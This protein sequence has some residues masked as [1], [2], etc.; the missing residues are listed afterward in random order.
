[1]RK[2]LTGSIVLS[3]GL[4]LFTG[5][6][7][8]Q[9]EKL[10]EVVLKKIREAAMSGTQLAETAHYL[11]DVSGPRLPGSEGFKRAA[12]WAVQTMKKWGLSNVA[13][14]PWGEFGR[15]WDLQDFN[16]AMKTPYYQPLHAYPEPWCGNTTGTAEGK[17]VVLT[18]SQATDTLYLREQVKTLRGKFILIATKPLASLQDFEPAAERFTDAALD[19]ISDLHPFTRQMAEQGFAREALR[20]KRDQLLKE[21]GVLGLISAP[22]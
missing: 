5:S 18:G 20:V 21:L 7:S 1:M 8:A 15:Q 22:Q 10:D 14:E 17:V 3:F 16:I 4:L 9:Q 2:N 19:T 11:T 13:M 6:I 12:T